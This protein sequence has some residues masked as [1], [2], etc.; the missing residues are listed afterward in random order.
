MLLLSPKA[1]NITHKYYFTA[2]KPFVYL[3]L[4]MA[5]TEPQKPLF[6]GV[7]H[8]GEKNYWTSKNEKGLVKT[9]KSDV[10]DWKQT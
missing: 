2:A 1:E 10:Y 3:V 4:I 9:F 6:W 7:P 8:V 5:W